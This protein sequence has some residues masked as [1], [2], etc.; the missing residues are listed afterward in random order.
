VS[1]TTFARQLPGGGGLVTLELYEEDKRKI[2]GIFHIEGTL[3]LPPKQWLRTM[4]AELTTIEEQ[5][6]KV[7]I[8]ELRMAGRDWSRV[9][10]GYEPLPGVPNGLRKVL[11]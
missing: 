2:C 4:R 11:T 10:Q 5:C 9:V 1:Y 3:K 6:R 8:A 7:G